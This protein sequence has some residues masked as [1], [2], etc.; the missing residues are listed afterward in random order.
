V[1][2]QL[3]LALELADRGW[4]VLPLSPTSK[5]PLPNC[6]VCR[7]HDIDVCRCAAAGRWCHGVRAASANP[8][9]LSA[10]WDRVPDAIVGL[11]AGPSGL[12]LIDI[13]NHAAPLPPNLATGLLPGINL[14]S[15]AMPSRLWNQPERYRDGR[16]TLR[17]LAALRGAG[18]DT[19]PADPAHQPWAVTTPSA[20]RHLWYQAPAQNLHQALSDPAGRHGLGWQIDI[21]AGWSYGIAPGA[22]TTA[23]RYRPDPSNPPTPGQ[24]PGWLA[25]EI[26]RVAAPATSRK[27][28]PAPSSATRP[29]DV[30]GR[31][32]Y[33]AA[34]IANGVKRLAGLTDGRKRALSALA[35][36]AGGLLAWAETAEASIVD[37]LV[38]AGAASG[39]AHSQ[40][41]RI[42]QRAVANGRSAPLTPRTTA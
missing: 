32:R 25:T 5:R 3:S 27:S 26:L 20:G 4:S 38:V 41:A 14:N 7:D 28:A 39:L 30:T 19:W 2:L 31:E 17:L 8:D 24:L 10:W 35:Y 34:V 9:R 12:L 33:L 29:A 21:K 22:T 15:E 6:Y 42:V 1:N 36:Q 11:A 18:A 13:D 37:Q 40:A 16:D 23:G